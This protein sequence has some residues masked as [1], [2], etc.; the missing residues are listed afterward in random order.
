VTEPF[1]D[2]LRPDEL[3]WLQTAL[4]EQMEASGCMSLDAAHGFLSATAGAGDDGSEAA[5]LD[6]VLGGLSADVGLRDLLSRFRAQLLIDLQRND[7][8]PL[9]LQMP[10]DDGSMLP[11][12][13]GWCQG[14]IVGIEFLGRGERD[15]M[16]SDERAGSLLLPALS[17]LMYEE[18]QWLEPPDENAHRE[19]VGELGAAAVALYHWRK[20]QL[21]S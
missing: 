5:E 2:R 12:P 3:D 6:R 4:A 14:Y 13:Y 8:G 9:I 16:L 18:S 10:C 19:T 20:Q 15:R 7:F 21:H 1:P 11:L 17:F